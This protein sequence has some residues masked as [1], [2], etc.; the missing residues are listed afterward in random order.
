MLCW[1]CTCFWA[2]NTL[3]NI[4]VPQVH[5]LKDNLK[6]FHELGGPVFPPKDLRGSFPAVKEILDRIQEKRRRDLG[7]AAEP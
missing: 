4:S 1:F 2:L 7:P 5:K 6:I 3:L